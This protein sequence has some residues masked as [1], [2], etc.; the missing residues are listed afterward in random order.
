MTQASIWKQQVLAQVISLCEGL[1]SRT[2]TLQE[3]YAFAEA[4]LAISYPDNNN[5]Q[6][7]IRQQLQL[8]RKEGILQ[9]NE[10]GSYTWLNT[11]LLPDEVE[12]EWQQVLQQQ[13]PSDKREYLV[14]VFARNRG[15]VQKAKECF[16]TRCMVEECSNH[17]T[18]PNGEDYIEVHHLVP[19]HR[20]GEDALWNLSVVCAH[21][22]RL[23]HFANQSDQRT[24]DYQLRKTVEHHLTKRSA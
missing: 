7:K 9:F 5:V 16:G 4:T 13:P 17:F 22:H 3:L 2:F 8:L 18:K 6:A 10:R 21:H 1:G 20:G 14:E 11:N 15:W 24:L 23:L 12:P 19:L